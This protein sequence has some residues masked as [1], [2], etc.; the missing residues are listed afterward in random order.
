[1]LSKI[2]GISAEFLHLSATNV[3]DFERLIPDNSLQN[4]CIRLVGDLT[5][6]PEGKLK[7]GAIEA[8]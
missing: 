7:A 5:D 3:A 2:R 8:R 6:A 1:M 4:N